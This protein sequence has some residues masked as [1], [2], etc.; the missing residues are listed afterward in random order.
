MGEKTT[1]KSKGMSTDEDLNVHVTTT[2]HHS[3]HAN[4]IN[5]DA[6]HGD[7][8]SDDGEE[9][10]DRNSVESGSAGLH[11][12]NLDIKPEHAPVSDDV[13]NS[14]TEL[15]PVA[16]ELDPT[17]SNTILDPAESSRN[18]AVDSCTHTESCLEPMSS[19]SELQS[20]NYTSFIL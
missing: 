14:S 3:E 12:T 18:N 16:A 15:Q 7:F 5:P 6:A 2:A 10:H 4:E 13:E 19:N 8:S 11:T 20:L 17:V 9:S 1:K